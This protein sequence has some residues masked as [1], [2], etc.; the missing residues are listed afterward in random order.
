M[1][2]CDIIKLPTYYFPTLVKKSDTT[3]VK[4]SDTSLMVKDT[5]AEDVKAQNL[6]LEGMLA[7]LPVLQYRANPAIARFKKGTQWLGL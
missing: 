5:T 1:E 2:A 4:K 3:L 6:Y 7:E